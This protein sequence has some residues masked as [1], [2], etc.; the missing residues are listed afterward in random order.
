MRTK[1]DTEEKSS[2][3]LLGI[4]TSANNIGSDTEFTLRA[5]SFLHIM[6]N[7]GLRI[8]AWGTPYFI[9]PQSE[10]QIFSCNM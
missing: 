4:M 9:V 5:G 10:K 3:F 1:F 7:R 8:D 2:K 6:N